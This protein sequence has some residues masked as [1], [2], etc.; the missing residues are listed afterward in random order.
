VE[1][2]GGK[3]LAARKSVYDFDCF[4]LKGAHCLY[5]ISAAESKGLQYIGSWK[6]P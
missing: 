1:G 4:S 5:E 6:R 3:F 2:E